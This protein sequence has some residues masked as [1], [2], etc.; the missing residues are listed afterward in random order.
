M[1]HIGM[2]HV[3]YRNE[4]CHKYEWV[5]QI[6]AT[7]VDHLWCSLRFAHDMTHSYV[8][9]DD[10]ACVACL[11]HMC[12]TTYSYVWH[13]SFRVDSLWRCLMFARDSFTSVTWHIHMCDMTRTH[14]GH[15]SFSVSTRGA[16]SCLHV[17]HSDVWRVWLYMRHDSF[18]CVT[19]MIVYETWVIHTLHD[20][21]TRTHKCLIHAYTWHD[22]FIWDMT[23]SDV[24][25]R[26]LYMRHESF[27]RYMTRSHVHVT[28]LIHMRYDSFRHLTLLVRRCDIIHSEVCT[29]FVT[30]I[31]ILRKLH[32]VNH[33]HTLWLASCIHTVRDT[34]AQFAQTTCCESYTHFATCI[35][36]THSSWHICTVR[37]N[38]M[39]WIIYTLDDLPHAYTQFVTHMHSSY[40]LHVV[41]HVHTLWLASCIYTVCDSYT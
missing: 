34:Y 38:N 20:T 25:H 35:M 6:S 3:T 30:H 27:I 8:W 18:R 15:D 28:R 16:T 4:S 26:W 39:L 1:S 17:T 10:F 32:V 7:Y 23:H 11:V 31:H 9:Y 22:L 40:K 2:S 5:M 37:A 19:Q 41:T 33:I 12:D 24:W 29:Q 13:D 36:H 21:F 14:A